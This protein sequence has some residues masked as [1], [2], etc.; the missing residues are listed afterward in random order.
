MESNAVYREEQLQRENSLSDLIKQMRTGSIPKSNEIL[1]I[2]VVVHI[3][4]KGEAVGSGTNISDE[5]IW[6]AINGLNEDYRKMAGTNGDGDGADIGVEFCLAQRDPSGNA[7]SGINRVSGCSVANYCTQGITAG[8]GQGANELNIK[9]LS[10]WPNQDYYNIWVVSE[11]ENNNGGSGIQG[12]AYFPTTSPVDGT[13]ILF[14]AFGTTGNLKS[15][16]NLNRTLTHELGHAFALFHTFQGGSCS[17]TNCTLQGDRVCDTPPTTLNSSCSNAACGGTQQVENYMDYTSQSC[18]NM[19]TEGQ[20]TR[21]R[22][23][24]QNSR[25]NLL[26]S[27]GCEPI[28]PVAADAGI[29][30]ISQPSGNLCAS[31]YQPMVT[32]R[33]YGSS[34]LSNVTIQ[35][36]TTGTWENFSW[37]GVLGPGNETD[38]ILP[39]YDGGWGNQTFR[40]RTQNPNGGA[41]SNTSNN[42]STASYTAVQ[43]GNNATVHVT[44]DILGGQTTWEIRDDGGTTLA[45]GG[46]YSNFDNGVVESASVCLVDGCYDFIIFDAVG[47]GLCCENGNGSY[48]VIDQDG[49]ILASGGNFE[50][51]ET[52]NFCFSGVGGEPPTAN[53]TASETNICAGESINFTSTSIGDITGYAWE[54][55][56]ATPSNSSASNPAN[57]TY[58]N[59]GTFN[60]QLTASNAFGNDIELKIDHI[61]VSENTTWYEDADGDGRGNPNSTMSSC[62]QP[63]GYVVNGDDCND[64]NASTWNECYDCLGVYNGSAYEDNCGT[65]DN[66]P[67]N[68][69]EQDCAGVW[70]GSAYEDNC[71]TCDDNPNNDCVQDC[72]GVWGGSAY[73]DN[74]GTCDDNPN[75]DC[76]QDCAGVWGG[77]AYFDDCGTCDDDTSNDCIPCENI[78]IVLVDDVNPSCFGSTDGFIEVELIK[79]GEDF[80][81]QWIDGS[82][83]TVRENLAAGTYQA[84]L[85]QDGCTDFIEVILTEPAPVVIDI[86]NVLPDDCASNPSGGF[87]FNVS[88]GTPPYSLTLES[89]AMLNSDFVGSLSNGEYLFTA[90]D[91]RGCSAEFNV[92]IPT[93]CDTLPN[94]ALITELCDG[95]GMVGTMIQA[96]PVE[97]AESYEWEITSLDSEPILVYTDAPQLDFTEHEELIPETDLSIRVRGI[98]PVFPSNFGSICH[99]MAIIDQP[100]ILS[101]PCEM[102]PLTF[103]ES[104]IL[105]NIEYAELYEVR[106]ENTETGERSYVYSLEPSLNISEQDFE[107][108][109]EYSISCR[110]NFRGIWGGYGESCT[111]YITE[112]EPT[113]QLL[114]EFCNNLEL[115]F[116]NVEL[117]VQPMEMAG[118]YQTIFFNIERNFSDTVEH[119]TPTILNHQFEHL[120]S[121]LQYRS[122]TRFAIDGEWS[123]WGSECEIGFATDIAFFAFN[124]YPNPAG[125]NEE[126]KIISDGEWKNVEISIKDMFGRPLHEEQMDFFRGHENTLT[127][128]DRA[129]GLYFIT[130]RHGKQRL[131]KRLIVD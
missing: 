123:P 5:Q 31:E 10:R 89:N 61:S 24:I 29:S 45:S 60:V 65:C 54:F 129:T 42:E 107:E 9:N 126:V 12:Y 93:D 18:K 109:T 22:L 69:C 127:I 4:H 72:A 105:E 15:Y 119:D 122:K 92:F 58:S 11:I 49:N 53:F 2:P 39:L 63:T 14:N 28:V 41:D 3:I 37:T 64:N 118:V 102:I 83:E 81:F 1:T 117:R 70:G 13:V 88:G 77:S 57:I 21:M 130:A 51:E 120:N 86:L 8:N 73:E 128:P 124:V 66:N 74:C 98:N 75:N 34:V 35:Y 76:E 85:T 55:E 101:G 87:S 97:G 106:V 95:F 17:E 38:I 103:G 44:L 115:N 7:H 78:D 110:V 50:F 36:R 33:N 26:N 43:D 6:S 116:D 30:A 82:T 32:L 16:T 27:N 90:E 62:T 67:S 96:S 111:G 94:T 79:D 99:Y 48:E 91:S 59:T 46:P 56:G 52:T 113:T 20:R 71:G 23:A 68:D 112:V 40:A 84:T 104:L 100:N 19:F 25:T 121:E 47:N 131:T 108:N 80:E 125:M 114:E